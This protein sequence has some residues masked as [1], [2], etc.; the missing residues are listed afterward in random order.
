MPSSN[1]AA[2]PD[3]IAM[4]WEC[5]PRRILDVGPGRGKAGIL[6]REYIG[7]PPIERI[8]AVE[9]EPSYITPRLRAMYDT[10]HKCEA[11]DLSDEVLASYDLVLMVD[12]IE[13]MEKDDG[14]NLLARIPGRIIV[15]T[16]RDFFE[17]PAGLPPSEKHRSLW[18]ATDF[19]DRLE[20]EDVNS[21]AMGAV[22]VRLGRSSIS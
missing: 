8:D 6:L 9:M 15:C 5:R 20:R 17:N 4:A 11:A 18:T 1:L 22:L 16:P 2:W 10:V 3:I 13:H 21:L 14:L 19:D 7:E 12:V